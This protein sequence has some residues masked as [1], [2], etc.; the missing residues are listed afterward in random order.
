MCFCCP[1][2][3]SEKIT[4]L[5]F[6]DFLSHCYY[7]HLKTQNSIKDNFHIKGWKCCCFC[8]RLLLPF[9]RNNTEEVTRS[10]LIRKQKLKEGFYLKY[11][12]KNIIH[13]SISRLLKELQ[14][15][16]V[17]RAKQC[18]SSFCCRSSILKPFCFRSFL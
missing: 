3:F 2:F 4:N 10:E 16:K 17:F 1:L 6:S 12:N 7:H 14:N 5:L 11:Y 15:D 8:V 13:F 9:N 18:T